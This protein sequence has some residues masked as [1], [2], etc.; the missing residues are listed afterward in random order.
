MATTAHDGVIHPWGGGDLDQSRTALRT[1]QRSHGRHR[2]G[3]DPVVDRTVAV[4]VLFLML[5]ISVVPWRN[6]EIFT[7]GVDIVVIAKAMLSLVTLGCATL[8]SLRTRRRASVGIGPAL[9]IGFVLLLS[10]LGA[11]IAGNGMATAVVVVRVV[12]IGATILLLL[13]CVPWLTAITALLVAMAAL[14]IV[15]AAT[16]A[17]EFLA[18]GRLGGGVPDIHPNELAGL[19]L[20]PLVGVIVAILR[21]GARPW[22]IT[23]LVIL[24]PILVATGSRTALI[25]LASG[26]LVAVLCNGVRQRSS[27]FAVLAV[28]PVGYSIVVFSSI[29][30]DLATRGGSTDTSST[31]GSRFDAWSVVW[32][33]GW[34]TWEKWVGV[35]LSVKEVKVDI[36]WRDVQVLDSSWA[37]LLAQGGLLGTLLVAGLVA[38][39]VVTAI[40]A[41]GRRWMLLPLLAVI[42]PRS[43]TESGLVDSHAAFVLFFTVVTLLARRSRHEPD[44][45]DVTYLPATRGG[46]LA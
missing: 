11:V 36:K 7:G 29:L 34:D 5:L 35:G 32:N 19:A 1:R 15:A 20:I 33:W 25:A 28:L 9:V 45:D 10:L 3:R 21:F 38:W 42:V 4:T 2:D 26:A 18:R 22:N 13:T 6:D 43:I 39:A 16:G 30:D 27:V 23:G 12:L 24:L 37:S 41:G 40:G 46:A 14:A 17:P 8:L 31:L 44:V